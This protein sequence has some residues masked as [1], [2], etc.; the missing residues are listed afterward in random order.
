VARLP[1]HLSKAPVGRERLSREAL[2]ELQR[3]RIVDAAIEVF[4]KRGYQSTTVDNIVSAAKIGVGS[5][6]AHFEGKDDCLLQ[7]YVRIAAE[8]RERIDAVVD[9]SRSWA[10]QTCAVLHELLAMIA[11]E[12]LKARVA[13]LEVQTGGTAAVALYTASV[14]EAIGFMTAGRAAGKPDPPP[15]A[16]FEEATVSGIAWLLQ[17]RLARGELDGVEDLFPEVAEVVLEPYLG[18][19]QAAKEIADF[20]AVP[21]GG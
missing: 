11:A 3:E 21:V 6:Y 13:L 14:Q 15:P 5:F 19:E 16:T 8:A 17:Q 7:C 12:P 2:S 10:Q 20:T 9:P 1:A 18:A 4:A